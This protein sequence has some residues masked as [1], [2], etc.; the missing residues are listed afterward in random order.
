MTVLFLV[1]LSASG[2]F[3]SVEKKKSEVAAEF[4]AMVAFSA[5]RNS[6]KVG[7]LV[8]TD[9][10]EMFIPPKKGTS[11]VL[12]LIRELLSFSPQR[13]RT[14]IAIAL[15]YLGRVQHKRGVV[16]LVSDFLAGGFEKQM[17]IVA[18]R[19]DLIAVSIADPRELALPDVGMIA[20][21]DVE[22]GEKTLLDTASASVRFLY[23]QE[24]RRRQKLLSDLFARMNVDH[25]PLQTG[26]DYVRDLVSFFKSRERRRE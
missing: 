19:H 22:T 3:G 14:D 12:R 18:R 10:I 24:G 13:A 17:A 23:A 21:E 7:L 25:I 5:I 8:F 6:D 11:H 1:D 2:S 20:L 16:F 9:H 15:E 4:C 26:D